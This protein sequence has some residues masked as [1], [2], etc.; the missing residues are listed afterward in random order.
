MLANDSERHCLELLQFLREFMSSE[1]DDYLTLEINEPQENLTYQKKRIR[2]LNK[3][4]ITIKPKKIRMQ[5]ELDEQLQKEIPT[6]NKGFQMLQR[7]GYKPGTGAEPL[8]IHLKHDK[9]GLGRKDP[10]ATRKY[11]SITEK[12]Q[13]KVVL[14]RKE[15]EFVEN[16]KSKFEWQQLIKDI[17]KSRQLCMSLD[18]ENGTERHKLWP[19]LEKKAVD[20]MEDYDTILSD[21][22]VTDPFED[23]LQAPQKLEILTKYLREQYHYCIWCGCKYDSATE[24][25]V[26]CPGDTR[27]AH[28]DE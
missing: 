20:P 22:P 10:L 2:Q 25:A 14:Q 6:S 16:V 3:E 5:E 9:L 18:V 28:E 27:K 24:M 13:K 19:P 26:E 17:N 1:D 15:H 12:N 4:A 8:Q 21:E 23:E 7:M 11:E